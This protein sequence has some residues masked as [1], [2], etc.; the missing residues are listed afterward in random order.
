MRL[1][2]TDECLRAGLGPAN[3]D[4]EMN[5]EMVVVEP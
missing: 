2:L 4:L 5:W 1:N 3:V